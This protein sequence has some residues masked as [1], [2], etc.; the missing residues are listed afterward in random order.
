MLDDVGTGWEWQYP[1]LRQILFDAILTAAKSR[2][3]LIFIDALVEAGPD[4]LVI[5]RFFHEL[6]DRIN[7]TR[8]TAKIC[9]SR[10]HYPVTANIL[11][12]DVVVEDHN[13]NGIA[14]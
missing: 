3:V 9:I 2:K 8:S 7:T 1:E 10:R 14:K 5:I 6:N 13:G 11:G 12:L 4:A